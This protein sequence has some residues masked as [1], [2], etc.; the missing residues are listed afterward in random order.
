MQPEKS[1]F[2]SPEERWQI[3]MSRS[4]TERFDLLM[5]LIRITRMLKNARIEHVV[6]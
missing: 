6:K 4:Y 2:L 1:P 3:A 5:K